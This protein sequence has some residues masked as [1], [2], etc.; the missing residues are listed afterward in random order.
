MMSNSKPPIIDHVDRSSMYDV[1][2]ITINYTF[3]YPIKSIIKPP[4]SNKNGYNFTINKS[5]IN[6]TN[7]GR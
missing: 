4:I 5:S 2:M 7:K 1:K 3:N 6:K